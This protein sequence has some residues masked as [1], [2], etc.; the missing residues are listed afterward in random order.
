[1]RFEHRIE[2][3]AVSEWRPKYVQY[4]QLKNILSRLP[5]IGSE[6]DY[7]PMTGA[8]KDHGRDLM[9]YC[10]TEQ[11]F[12]ERINLELAKVHE[13]YNHRE[14]EAVK[15]KQQI[16]HQVQTLDS[17]QEN[18]ILK[19]SNHAYKMSSDS[20]LS[21]ELGKHLRSLRHQSS[22][23]VAKTRIKKALLEFYRSLELLRNYRTL[24]YLALGKILKKFDK[25]THRNVGPGFME[26]IRKLPFYVSTMPESLCTDVE[27]IYRRMFTGGDR[28]KALR[29]LRIPNPAFK[30]YQLPSTMS[31]LLGGLMISLCAIIGHSILRGSDTIRGL[32]LIYAALGL[33]LLLAFLFS[34]NILVWDLIH[35]NYK[36]IFEFDHRTALHHSE[37]SLLVG[38][39]SL[40][41]LGFVAL[42]LNGLLDT[43]IPSMI[44]QVIWCCGT[45]VGLLL[46]PLPI[47][48]WTSRL[49]LVR[50]LMRI[51]AAPWLS[52]RFRD[53]F[54]NDQIMSLGFSLQ[55]VGLLVHLRETGSPID[56]NVSVPNVWYISLISCLPALC[57]ILQSLRRFID[58]GCHFFP[59]MANL[60]KYGFSFAAP[61]V[62]LL[63]PIH[64]AFF[65]L[66][67]AILAAGAIYSLIWDVFMDWGLFQWDAFNYLLRETTLFRFGSTYYSAIAV[68]SLLRFTWLLPLCKVIPS[69]MFT[70]YLLAVGEV[71]RRIVWNL[72]R[73]EYEQVNNCNTLRAFADIPLP[74]SA[75][76]LFYQDMVEVEIAHHVHE[77]EEAEEKVKPE[78]P[79]PDEEADEPASDLEDLSLSDVEGSGSDNE[80][81]DTPTDP[82]ILKSAPL[83]DGIYVI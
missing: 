20:I 32:A 26:K 62:S 38:S 12:L 82:M 17:L 2:K 60:I 57:R 70:A 46:L 67:I 79:V 81:D 31:G 25:R 19:K 9:P 45:L 52:I 50:T 6:E 58:G 76:D 71:L 28:S 72:F 14:V 39:F 47:F 66:R 54:I 21:I 68:D 59:H 53:F 27:N 56:L 23:Q 10:D 44:D 64:G 73:V 69:N 24:N 29:K 33:P 83:D 65:Y 42:S 15:R 36:F 51:V 13:F 37:F 34:V 18:E 55:A 77:V 48:F 7:D 63:V 11:L 78:D 75:K 43:H 3:E 40:V 49:W 61:W 1:M 22:I 5:H 8:Y 74:Y 16:L 80:E 30:T 4:K 41:Y 35:I